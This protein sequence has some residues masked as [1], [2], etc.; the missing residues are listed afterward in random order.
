MPGRLRAALTSLGALLLSACGAFRPARTPIRSV[1]V[2]DAGSGRCLAVLLPGRYAIPEGF[3]RGGFGRTVAE[4]G[5]AMDVVAVDAHL[6]YYRTRTVLERIRTDVIEPAR[7]RGYEEIW[8][9]GTSLGGL[10]SLLYLR[11][12]REE[13]RGVLAIAPY[14]GEEDVL[15]EI[16]AAGGPQRW[17]QP[18]VSEAD[19]GRIV[20]SWL[21]RG[22][23]SGEDVPV[24]LGWGSSD[25]FDR[26]N[27]MFASLLPPE[28][29]LT[30]HGGH[31]M[32]T[33]NRIWAQFLE[34][35]KPCERD[36]R[37]R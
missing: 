18:P 32:E 16:E 1:V 4:K 26:S 33:W 8:L 15:D 13:I 21:A 9:A 27:R 19:I 6:G 11:D 3:K 10:G 7:R 2:H 29:V 28:R 35:A 17:N 31:D 20:W 25:R 24:Y 34:V 12:H 36:T 14:L 23:A 30:T 37:T 22:G 5:I